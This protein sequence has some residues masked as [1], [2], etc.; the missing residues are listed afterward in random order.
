MK[1]GILTLLYVCV[2]GYMFVIIAIS[3]IVLYTD[4]IMYLSIVIWVEIAYLPFYH[5]L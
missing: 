1:R 4:N 2:G 5:R 3:Q